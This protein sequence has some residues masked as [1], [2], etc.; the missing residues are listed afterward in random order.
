[1]NRGVL[2]VS[3]GENA[4]WE[5]K[6][7]LLSLKRSNPE[8]V[9]CVLTDSPQQFRTHAKYVT[10]ADSEPYGRWA[11][12]NADVFSPFEHTLYIDADTRIHG[13]LTP[14]FDALEAGWD[15]VATLSQQQGTHHWLNGLDESERE[16]TIDCVGFLPA[17]VQGGL[18][19]FVQNERTR[20]FFQAW[21][22]EW[23]SVGIEQDQAALSRALRYSPM[24][25][26]LLGRAFNNGAVT[27]HRFG[28]A[29][30]D[31]VK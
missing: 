2:Y 10:R 6:E 27:N 18:W 11:K 7:S 28:S 23:Q 17:Q 9:A 29:R 25:V 20:D 1:M 16:S 14:L 3:Y 13:K 22:E 8:L 30:R 19:S 5:C 4:H 31:D 15:F 24:K 21:R 12:L 26:A